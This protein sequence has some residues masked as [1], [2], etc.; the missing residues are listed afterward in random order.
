MIIV[1]ENINTSRKAVRPL[2]EA[3]DKEAIQAVVREV[4]EAGANYVDVNCGTF[5]TEEPE[6]LPW[7]VEVVQEAT[8]LPLCID[9]PNPVAMANA[10]AKCKQ[11]AI[12]NSITAETKRYDVII[13]VVKQYNPKVLALCMDDTGMP[14]GVEGRLK[15]ARDLVARLESDGVE[16]DDILVDPLVFV[17]S[18]AVYSSA[19]ALSISNS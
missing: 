4:T 19:D 6:M 15:I 8:E 7:L 5:V 9:S 1:A 16:R 13:P 17:I 2:V 11:Q 10:L 18:T 3:K 12:L 14:D